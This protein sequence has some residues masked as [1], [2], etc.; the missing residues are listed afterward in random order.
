MSRSNYKRNYR[1]VYWDRQ[2]KSNCKVHRKKPATLLNIYY[3]ASIFQG[4]W[5]G[6]EQFVLAINAILSRI[7][8]CI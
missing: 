5:I 3:F 6:L 7:N 8:L 2:K 4:I 1:K